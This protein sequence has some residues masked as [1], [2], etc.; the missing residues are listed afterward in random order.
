[1]KL[2]EELYFEIELKG[3]K[4]A[5]LKFAN[6]VT[7]GEL[8]EFFELTSDHIVYGDDFDDVTDN[9]DTTMSI[10]NDEYG[11]ELDQFDPEDFLSV[12]CQAAT[13]LEI[14]GHFYDIDDEEYRFISPA[15][16][17]CYTDA[18]DI[19]YSDDLDEEAYKEE[20]AAKDDY[21]Y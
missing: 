17:P 13:E 10:V 18:D 12:F 14:S 11:I 9:T 3:S 5:L 15:G 2:H 19:D 1:M 20:L 4:A 21:D 8:D 6:F 16:D 7:S